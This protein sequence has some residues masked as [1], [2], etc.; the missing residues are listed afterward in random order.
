MKHKKLIIAI[1]AVVVLAAA[2]ALAGVAF[3][4]WTAN[5]STPGNSVSTA[6]AGLATSGLPITAAGLVPQ[7]SPAEDAVDSEY[8]SVSYF[9]VENT[10]STPLMFYG[11]LSGGTDTNNIAPY[12][13]VRVW[14]LGATT[15]PSFWT[16]MP[17]G[18]SDTFQVAGPWLAYEGPLSGLWSGVPAGLNYLSSRG[19]SGSWT[20]TPIAAGQYGVYRVAVWLDSS[21]PDS[22]QNSTV[23]FTVNF[24]GLSPAQWAADNYDATVKY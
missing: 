24:T 9:Y 11:W 1:I 22:T 2:V 18:W 20:D 8:G 6:N 23:G 5:A 4:W 15:A 12:V 3:G 21:A 19:W 13:D 10:G 17:S 7:V 14:L 16:G